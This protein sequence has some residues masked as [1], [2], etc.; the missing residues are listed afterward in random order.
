MKFYNRENELELLKK[1]DKLKE[2]RSVLSLIIG[3]RRVG[4]TTLAL[5][6]ADNPIYFFISRKS[7]ELLCEEFVEELAKNGIKVYGE[8][9]KFGDLFEY[10][11]D[12]SKNR[13]ITLII[14]EFQ[15]FFRVNPSVFSSIQKIWDLNKNDSHM[16]LIICGSVYSLMKKIFEDYKE[17]L[18]A[19]ADFKIDLKPLNVKVLKEILGDNSAY[20]PENLLDFYTITGGVAKY[21]ELFG[22]YEA[23]DLKKMIDVMLS[24]YSL[25]LDEGKNRLIEE[26]GKE[27]ATY[28]SI[29]ALIASSKTSKSEI[30]S[31]LQRNISGH[32]ERLEK[33]YNIIK[34][35]KPINAK[36]NSKLQKY[37]IDD[38]FLNFWFRFFYKYAS[39]IESENFEGLKEIIFRDF[40]TYKGKFLEKLFKELLKLQG[41]WS[42]IGSYWERGNKNEI[43]IVAVDEI[44]KKILIAEVKLNKKRANLNELILKSQKLINN[45]KNFETEYKILS[46]E[47]IEEMI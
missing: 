44:N 39:F 8:F 23:F 28:F 17:P 12:L 4:K 41:K 29:L 37:E 3:R 34:P 24:P 6:V 9:R 22:L 40:D 30:E 43:D 33:D 15:E 1:A 38:N 20:S 26:F 21:I 27:Y 14:D 5:K 2:K 7:E 16:H 13:P 11:M 46:L 45:Y 35:I 19:R 47:N 18:F 25:F 36:Q 10:L 31:V 32:L 42:K